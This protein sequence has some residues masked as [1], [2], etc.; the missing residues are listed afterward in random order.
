MWWSFGRLRSWWHGLLGLG[1]AWGGIWDV[2]GRHSNGTLRAQVP[3]ACVAACS[4]RLMMCIL[5]AIATAIATTAA[6]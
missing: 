5:T 1:E 2:E 4:P 6:D 3:G